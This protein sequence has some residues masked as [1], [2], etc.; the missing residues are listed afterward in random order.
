MKS[1]A[2]RFSAAFLHT[3]AWIMVALGL[4]MFSSRIPLPGDMWLNLPH[5]A[6]VIQTA[7][8]MFAIWGFQIMGSIFMWP[9]FKVGPILDKACAGEL[10]ASILIF[11]L[12]VFNGLSTV[13]FTIWLGGALGQA[14]GGQ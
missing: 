11:G 5:A 8:L 9:T 7:G 4:I 10:S 3:D 1:I 6:T 12:L 13:A 2:I 14:V